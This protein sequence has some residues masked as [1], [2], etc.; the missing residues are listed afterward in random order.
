MSKPISQTE[1]RRLKRR[2]EELES[3]ERNRRARYGS[4]YPGGVN[5]ATYH[6][7][8]DS[9]RLVVAAK[10]ARMCGHAVIVVA[11]QHFLRFYA[12]P[13]PKVEV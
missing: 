10:T 8:D 2:V 6:G 12:L 9:D 7:M 1:A 3:A 5:I 13:H 4:E 11:D